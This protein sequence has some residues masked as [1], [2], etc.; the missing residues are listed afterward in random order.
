MLDDPAFT[1]T[2]ASAMGCS[3]GNRGTDGRDQQP[4]A[5]REGPATKERSFESRAVPRRRFGNS[6]GRA[7]CLDVTVVQCNA[8][9]LRRARC[10]WRTHL[11]RLPRVALEAV[12]T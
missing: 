11:P 8:D 6:G 10:R 4:T 7:K 2:I 9:D 12:S 5:T 1:T 3:S